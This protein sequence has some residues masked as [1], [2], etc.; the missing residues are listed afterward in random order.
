MWIGGDS[1]RRVA[2]DHPVLVVGGTRGT[3]RLIA[4]LLRQQGR[5]VRVLARDPARA[6]AALDE[7]IDVVGGDITKRATLPAAIQ[8]ASHIIFT[9]GCRSGHPV[10]ESQIRSTEYGGVCHTIAAARDVGFDGRLLYM[11]SSGV[12]A[13][14]VWTRA[15]NLWKG[16]TLIW[17]CRA[18][19][20]LRSSGL[21]YTVVR[22]GML[23]NRPGGEHRLTIT[24]AALPL[25]P[26]YRI[27]REDVAQ[28]FVAALE[29]ARAS[30]A[31]FEAVWGPPGPVGDLCDLLNG[32]TV[33]A[34]P[35][36]AP[37]SARRRE[38]P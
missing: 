16:N 15:L 2:R 10:G 28:L 19:A 22:T 8:G 27:A 12:G 20:E 6:R 26:R 5:S 35:G 17:R 21:D 38:G 23:L 29:H 7:S 37:C 36:Q 34:A 30:R 9:A 33:D 13:T 25:T 31:T 14:S 4:R 32:L 3:G 11:T 24:Q 1:S 18:E